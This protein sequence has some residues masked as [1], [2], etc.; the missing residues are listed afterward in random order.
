[1]GKIISLQALYRQ[2][3]QIRNS[4]KIVLVTGCFD[5]LHTTHEVFLQKARQEGDLLLV[6]LET[7]NR[8]RQI[9]GRGRPVNVWIKRAQNLAR[10]S[11]T[12][13]VFPLPEKM[14]EPEVQ[15]SLIASIKPDILA[16]SSHTANL[17]KK[18]AIVEKFGGKLRIVLPHN[19]SISSTLLLDK[20]G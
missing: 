19:P 11:A 2:F 6:G 3:P 4:Q 12:D 8:V 20:I 18:K 5:I 7:D 13:F 17:D 10:L 14:A 16:V 1:M 15:Y 9:K